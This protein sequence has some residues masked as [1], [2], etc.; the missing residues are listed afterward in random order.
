MLLRGIKNN[1]LVSN[2][3][4]SKLLPTIES[5]GLLDEAEG[6]DLFFASGKILRD[7]GSKSFKEAVL[8]VLADSKPKFP[9]K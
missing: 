3:N 7:F 6:G 9:I 2:K 4:K 5:L 8:S 1:G